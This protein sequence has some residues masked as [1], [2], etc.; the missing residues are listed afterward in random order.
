MYMKTGSPSLRL[1]HLALLTLMFCGT[2]LVQPALMASMLLCDAGQSLCPFMS[3]PSAS[4]R[5]GDAA[6]SPQAMDLHL[7][8]GQHGYSPQGH[9]EAAPAEQAAPLAVPEDMPSPC[10]LD[11]C[12]S[13]SIPLMAE[14]GRLFYQPGLSFKPAPGKDDRPAFPSPSPLFHPPKA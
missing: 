4:S 9:A 12:V 2:W 6:P 1:R 7:E 8:H 11:Q 10:P 14:R 3:A 5:G 13:A